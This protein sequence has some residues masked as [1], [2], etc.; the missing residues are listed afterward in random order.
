MPLTDH[1]LGFEV[2]N[3]TLQR[4]HNEV[5]LLNRLLARLE[6]LYEKVKEAEA[7]DPR[8]I[9]DQ[10][11]DLPPPPLPPGVQSCAFHWYA[12]PACDMVKMI[13]WLHQQQNT[14]ADAPDAYL[15]KVI[16]AIEP[17][18]NKSPP[19]ARYTRTTPRRTRQPIY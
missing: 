6:Y 19:T 18:R 5:S 8:R 13:G 15:K 10:D 2:T 11:A 16:P 4:H 1:V 14:D 12:M 3:E 17:W 9:A 7:I